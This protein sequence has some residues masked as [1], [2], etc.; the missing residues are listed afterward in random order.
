[1]MNDRYFAGRKISAEIFDGKTKY[2]KSGGKPSEEDEEAEKQRL[3]R[4]A[5]WLEEGGDAD[6]KTP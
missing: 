3:E 6:A 4:Y 2:E 1:M 5:K